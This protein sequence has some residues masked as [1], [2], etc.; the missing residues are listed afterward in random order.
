VTKRLFVGL[1]LPE[2]TRIAL[3]GID[4]RIKGLR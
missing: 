3:H 4:P 1:E 2:N